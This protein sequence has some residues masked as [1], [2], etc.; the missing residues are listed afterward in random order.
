MRILAVELQKL[1][2]SKVFL[3][4]TAVVFVLNGYLVFRTANSSDAKPEQYKAVYEEIEDLSDTE[5]LQWLDERLNEY[6]G[7]QEYSWT[8]LAE[9]YDECADILGYSEYLNSIDSQAEA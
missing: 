5:K 3:L 9:L 1:F 7:Q 2:S 6:N 8:V 4:I